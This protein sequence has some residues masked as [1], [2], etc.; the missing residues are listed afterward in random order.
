MYILNETGICYI[1]IVLGN[2]KDGVTVRCYDR[3]RD[4]YINMIWS[5]VKISKIALLVPLM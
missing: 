3:L 4:F 2:K 5:K 1:S